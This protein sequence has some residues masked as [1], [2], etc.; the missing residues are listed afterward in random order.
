MQI[1][2]LHP[3]SDQPG[4]GLPPNFFVGYVTPEWKQ[5]GGRG[6]LGQPYG[7]SETD[8]LQD[9]DYVNLIKEQIDII[10]EEYEKRPS[11]AVLVKLEAAR[12]EYEVMFKKWRD[13]RGAR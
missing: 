10:A 11:E 7:P 8:Q 2:A 4:S 5:P 6:E 9:I 12:T 13:E 1:L 3:G